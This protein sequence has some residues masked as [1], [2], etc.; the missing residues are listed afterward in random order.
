MTVV[1]ASH[2]QAEAMAL[3]DRLAVLNAGRMEQVGEP[4]RLYR[5]PSNVFVAQFLGMPPM[6]LLPGRLVARPDGLW[7]QQDD[8]GGPQTPA[9]C[10][11]LQDSEAGPMAASAGRPVLCGIRPE[12]L[13][14]ARPPGP[15]QPA[16]RARVERVEP[17]GAEAS[18]RLRLTGGLQRDLAVRVPAEAAWRA[19]DTVALQVAPERALFFDPDS[20]VRLG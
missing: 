1:C 11:R 5:Q 9:F 13:A 2:D 16:G 10:F 4:L 12:D 6:N 3:G 17:A 7:F 18:L 8:E 15:G 14:C 20:G 19:G